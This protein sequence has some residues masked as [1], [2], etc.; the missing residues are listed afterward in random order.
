MHKLDAELSV[1]RLTRLDGQGSVK[2]FCDLAVGEM[3]LIR[4]LRVVEGKQGLFVS[5]PRELGKNGMWYETVLA[6]TK[7]VREEISRVVLD[8]YREEVIEF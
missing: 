5:M 6:L 1:K 7:H 2:A 8:A 3:L 4:G